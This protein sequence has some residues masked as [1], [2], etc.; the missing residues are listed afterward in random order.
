MNKNKFSLK[1]LAVF[2]LILTVASVLT[3]LTVYRFAKKNFDEEMR[4][5]RLRQAEE[6]ASLEEALSAKTFDLDLL[7]AL[8]RLYAANSLTDAEKDALT[9]SLLHA[10]ASGTGDDYSIYM[11][12]DDY[13]AHL[14]KQ[15]SRFVGIGLSVSADLAKTE[16]GHGLSV[17]TVYRDSPAKE[18]GI[19]PGDILLS[20]DGISFEGKTQEEAASL[21][22]GE[23]G[24]TV[25]LTYL[26]NGQIS[27][28]TLIRRAV[29]EDTVRSKMLCDGIAYILINRFSS[30]TAKQLASALESCLQSGAR[31]VIFDVRNNP[32]GLVSAVA[33]CLG[34]LLPDGDLVHVNYA[35][36]TESNYTYHVKE[37]RLLRK[38]E[39]SEDAIG[40]QTDMAHALSLPTAVLTNENTASAGE[41][42]AAALRDY[43]DQNLIRARLFGEKTYGKGTVQATH[44]LPNGGAFKLTVA[45]Y[46]PPYSD[47][48]DAIG[49]TPDQC[50]SLPDAYRQTPIE[51]I[52]QNADTQLLSAVAWLETLIR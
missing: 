34:Y 45:T 5:M 17:L 48:F 30:A 27:S 22:R 23:E 38:T 46:K 41:I 24:S 35:K 25:S 4:R 11:S 15:S 19:L 33:E 7:L 14:E 20:A 28:V 2:L 37:G 43:R 47:G 51:L 26:R 3:G 18:G 21:V 40:T 6:M 9:E 1:T 8:D 42:F 52:P 49:I 29:T 32:G 10:Y 13:T 36:K 16:H 12:A 31:A 39:T 44:R 50:V